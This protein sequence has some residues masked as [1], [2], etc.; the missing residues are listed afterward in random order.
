MNLLSDLYT[1]KSC[2]SLQKE[3][4]LA[5]KKHRVFQAHFPTNPILPGFLQ[6]D[7][8]QEL[9]QIRFSKLKKVKFIHMIKPDSSVI[10][11]KNNNKI[12]LYTTD[13]KKI[14]EIIYE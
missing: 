4:I 11:K 3:I 9:F 10:F 1:V 2:D 14:S 7:I 13:N 12:L 8:A 5:D 6:L